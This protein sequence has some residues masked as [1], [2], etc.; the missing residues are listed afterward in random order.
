MRLTAKGRGGHASLPEGTI[1]AIG[2]LVDYL[3][4]AGLVSDAQRPFF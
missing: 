3:L 4:D 1:N 2:L